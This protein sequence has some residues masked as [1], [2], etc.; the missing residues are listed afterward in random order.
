MTGM[1]TAG[2]V[3]S[4]SPANQNT[5]VSVLAGGG[6]RLATIEQIT[7]ITAIP[8][9]DAIV[10]ARVRGWDVVVKRDEFAVGDLCVYI[11]VD[12]LLDVTDPAFAFLASRG[13]RTDAEGNSGHVLKTA[14]LRGQ[15]SQGLVLPVGTFPA[16]EGVTAGGAAGVDVTE[17]LPVRRWNPPM[18]AALAGKVIGR[19][20]SWIPMTDEDR[21]ENVGDILNV[22]DVDWFAT[23]KIDGTSTTVYVNPDP[24]NGFDP[25]VPGTWAGVYGVCSR[26]LDLAYDETQTQWVLAVRLGLHDLCAREWPGSRVA[27]QGETYG[28]GVQGNPLKVRGQAFAVFTVLVDGR[29]LPRADWPAWLVGFAVPEVPGLV[30]PGSVEG[31][32]AQ[33]EVLESVVA[34]G[35]AAEGVVWRARDA[36]RVILP[37]GMNVRASFKAISRKYLLKHDR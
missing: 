2:V 29:E 19:R 6:R 36:A 17:L 5:N 24:A 12:S 10:C 30:F 35:R 25:G 18:P 31:A 4:G 33:V 9:A 15:Y 37:D 1:A 21:V 13:V 11:E 22:R 8:D 28:E 34:P 23:E 32:V 20:P 16:L 27:V 26:N 3:D 14:R 7:A